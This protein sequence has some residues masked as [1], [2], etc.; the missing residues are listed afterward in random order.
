MSRTKTS[1]R[2]RRVLG[3]D[4]GLTRTG[5]ALCEQRGSR[6]TLLDAG[7]INTEQRATYA[8]RLLTLE[9][10]LDTLLARHHPHEVAVEKLFFAKNMKTAMDVGQAR[11]VIL[12]TLARH[13]LTPTEF[14]PQQI[15]IGVTGYGGAPKLQVQKMVQLLLRLTAPPKPDDVADAMAA[16]LTALSIPLSLRRA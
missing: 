12:L 1:V 4:P 9:R 11:G 13:R 15:K 2:S 7:C 14:T 8:E 16:A 6:Y 5:Y 3:I 10:E